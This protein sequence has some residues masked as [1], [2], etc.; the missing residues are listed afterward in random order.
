MSTSLIHNSSQT[1]S[2]FEASA[3]TDQ[4]TEKEKK[5]F[6]KKFLDNA[7]A[8]ITAELAALD[9]KNRANATIRL[10]LICATES[11]EDKPT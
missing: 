4:M 6:I 1:S 5:A 3:E 7:R 2:E 10:R 9:A 11:S 8:Q